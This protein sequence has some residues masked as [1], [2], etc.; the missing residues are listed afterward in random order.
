MALFLANFIAIFA[1]VLSIA[2]FIRAMLS[3]FP[4]G[5]DNRLVQILVQI[6]DPILIPLRR[7]IPPMGLFDLTPMIAMLLLYAIGELAR[8]AALRF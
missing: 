5:A 4:V 1:Q 2:I 8:D 7:V 3:W 6:T